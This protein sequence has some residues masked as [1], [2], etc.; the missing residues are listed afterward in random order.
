MR[1]DVRTT[2][3]S[4]PTEYSVRFLP[5]GFGFNGVSAMK[6][7]SSFALIMAAA[8]I[9]TATPD[10]QA[11][12]FLWN[13]TGS[14][15]TNGASWTNGVAPTSASSSNTTDDVQFGSYGSNNNTVVLTSTR[16]TAS[17]AFLAGAN[18]YN[19]NSFDGAQTLLI[20]KGLTN[21]S[22][23]TQ[24]FGISVAQN[25]GDYTWTQVT[26]GSL[27]FNNNVGLT[28]SS[29][30][31]SRTLTL[32]GGGT[33]TFNAGITSG[34]SP[35][36][37]LT[38]NNSGGTVK[39]GASNAI[40]GGV[41]L[42]AGT[43]NINNNNALGTGVLTLTGGATIDNTSGSAVVNTGNNALTWNN[44]TALN[45]GSVTNTAANNL[46]LGTGTV[47]LTG[48]RRVDLLGTGTKLTIGDVLNNG[49][50]F[51]A[52]GAGN[53]LEM[54]GLSLSTNSTPGTVTLD[55]TA[56]LNITGAI[57]NGTAAGSGLTVTSSGTN[58]FSGNNTYTG[59]TAFGGGTN[60][61]S[62][63]NR[64]AVGNVTI[65]GSATYVRL[66][67][68]GA[69]SSSSSLVGMSGTIAASSTLD[70]K[71]AGDVTFNSY[72]VSSSSA[73]GSM[74][75]TN[76]SGSSKTV[77]FTNADNYITQAFS[78]P[79]GLSIKSADLTLDF[80]GNIQNSSTQTNTTTFDGAGNFI[81]RGSLLDSTNATGIRTIAKTGDGKLTLQ[82]ASNNYSGPTLVSG[83]TL[84]VGT[85]GV[86]PSASS[87]TVS[88]GATL[89]FNQAS[90]TNNVGPLAVVGTLEQ[91]LITITSS[92]AV[93]LAGATLKVNGTPILA[94]Y[95]LVSGAPLTG[96]RPNLNPSISGYE[97]S[98]SGNN[99]LLQQIDT[100]IPAIT[101]SSSASGVTG[102]PFQY[103]IV[104]DKSPTSFNAI[105]LPAGLNVDAGTGLITGRPSAVGTY[106]VTLSAMNSY[107]TGSAGLTL[108]VQPPTFSRWTSARGLSGA[109]AALGADA[110]GNGM[111]NL[112]EYG[113]LADPATAATAS[114]TLPVYSQSNGYL[115]LTY[116]R[117]TNDAS[118]SVRA[119]YSSDLLPGG[120]I[121]ETVINGPVTTASTPLAGNEGV[122]VTV[123]APQPMSSGSKGFLRAIIA[124]PTSSVLVVGSSIMANWTS[125]ATDLAPVPILNKGRGGSTTPQWLSSSSTGYWASRVVSQANSAL[126]YYCGSNDV[127]AGTSSATIASNTIAF[128]Q[129]FWARYPDAP[130]IYLAIQK[131]P[132]RKTSGQIPKV[133]EVNNL[134]RDWIATQPR[135]RYIDCNP[136]LVDANDTALPG[137]FLSDNLHLT[138]AGYA[139]MTTVILPVL[140]EMWYYQVK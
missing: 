113:F 92:G 57:V 119:E 77:T 112:M 73:G 3:K 84:E 55:G 87:I 114:Q 126:I 121:P 128:F 74:N 101:S 18:S 99:L 66:E 134:M 131:A 65:S 30:S 41:T 16:A 62:G 40:S 136:V 61:I 123:R 15:W 100:T 38:I 25:F 24:T 29:S 34:S 8:F 20:S 35:A 12:N 37:R 7:R 46:N 85:E 54:R 60:I 72:G 14:Q 76:S 59:S 28:A 45:F 27:V 127:G 135:A 32:A 116:R 26:G 129:D 120:W 50:T 91:N 90:G 117:R 52:N 17:T 4:L 86:L 58:T 51:T 22:T 56:N 63:D 105:G 97:L 13:N 9:T 83:G 80:A 70:F 11:V 107:G 140:Q 98:I 79:R 106:T 19:I 36:S 64:A 115:T 111:N 95:T 48:S 130:A 122:Q 89:R 104:A 81:V 124:Q 94:S 68:I 1:M 103:Q 33:F 44:T 133:N 49:F 125:V 96:T 118:V 88:S 42:T 23:A 102:F 47:T 10:A 108:S 139:A 31:V 43:L 75:F 137:M 67:N 71:A 93:N 132:T 6:Q 39:L 78:G 5:L 109:D 82:G 21:S 138:P 53:T 69:I 110:D 2:K